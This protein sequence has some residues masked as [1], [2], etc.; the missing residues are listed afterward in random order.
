MNPATQSVA[1]PP[2]E[3]RALAAEC[4]RKSGAENFGLTSDDVASILA[5]VARKYAPAAVS[6]QLREFC[7]SLKV[8]ELVL[9]RACAAGNERAWESFMRRYR[10]RLYEIGLQIA[11]EEAAAR[12]LSDSLYADLYGTITREGKRVSK[13]ESYTG[14][15]SLEGWLR[16]VM[17]QEHVN[18]FRRQ[19]RMV[20]L[21]QE[22]E[23]GKQFASP[24]P[25]AVPTVHPHLESATDELLAALAPEERFILAAYFLD[26]RTLAEIARVL[27]VHESTISRKLDKLTKSLRKRLLAGLRRRGMSRRQ[28]EEALAVDVRDLTLNIRA[29]LAQD[30]PAGAF[31]K[32]Q[33]EAPGG[34]GSGW[35]SKEIEESQLE[36]SANGLIRT[37]RPRL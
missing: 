12:E 32:K 1:G 7:I 34:D 36:D 18:R 15:G 17:V 4:Y 28:A 22:T 29:R 2:P 25:E 23:E 14:R 10:E 35:D 3:I 31:P 21:D 37:Q 5:E 11:R 13:L 20:S 27:A 33:A 8:E 19:K 24:N 16:T 9:A 6:A 26:D 30:S